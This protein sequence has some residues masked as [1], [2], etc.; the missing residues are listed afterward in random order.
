[1]YKNIYFISVHLHFIS[2]HLAGF[3]YTLVGTLVLLE[4]QKTAFT[5]FRTHVTNESVLLSKTWKNNE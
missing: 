3:L 4:E 1:M 2:F 5:Y